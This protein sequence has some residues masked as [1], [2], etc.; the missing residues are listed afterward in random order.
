[1]PAPIFYQFRLHIPHRIHEEMMKHAL[2]ESPNECCGLL[3]GQFFDENHTDALAVKLYP[4]VNEAGSPT[5]F[6]AA[7]HPSLF[8]AHRDMRQQQFEVLAVYH[9]HPTSDPIPSKTDREQWFYDTSVHLIIG[10]KE[11]SPVLRGWWLR[12]DGCSEAELIF[13]DTAP[14]ATPPNSATD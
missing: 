13:S 12:A 5:A 10:L 6:R 9:S 3:G 7:D 11:S 14:G 4:L 2:A 1:M 8:H